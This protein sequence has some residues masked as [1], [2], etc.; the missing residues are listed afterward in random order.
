MRTILDVKSVS[1][2]PRSPEVVRFPEAGGDG[3]VLPPSGNRSGERGGGE[4][5]EEVEVRVWSEG[6]EEVEAKQ[7]GSEVNIAITL[8]RRDSFASF[9]SSVALSF[10][11]YLLPYVSLSLST[12]SLYLPLLLLPLNRQNCSPH[13]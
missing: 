7:E 4:G 8:S 10:S 1:R 9:S 11:I 13:H 3:A 12:N 5:K 2:R 6:R